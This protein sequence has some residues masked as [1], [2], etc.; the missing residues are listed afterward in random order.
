MKYFYLAVLSILCL[1]L[2]DHASSQPSEKQSSNRPWNA[3]WIAAQNDDGISY[4]VFYFRKSMVLPVKPSSFKVNVSADNRFKLYVNGILVALGPARGDNYFWNYETL[5][6]APYLVEGNNSIAALVWNEAQ[7]RPEA[8]MS[9]RTA[10]ILQGDS[11]L[12]DIINT[13]ETW[14]CV[15]D[16][17]YSALPGIFAAGI[18]EMVDMNQSILG[19]NQPDFNDNNWPAA[20]SVESGNLKINVSLSGLW[21]L[22][23]SP[24]PAMELTV[25]RIP[26]LRKAEGMIVPVSFPAHPTQVKIPANTRVTLLLDQTYLTNAYVTLNF[27]KGKNTRIGLKYAES[28]VDEFTPYGAKKMNRNDVEGKI[29]YG[30]RDSLVSSGKE[31]QTY[32]TLYWRTFRYIQLSIQTGDEP[33]IL[34]DMYG[35][36]TGYPF[37]Q[38]A[39]FNSN[40]NEIQQMLNIGWRTVRLCA[41]ETYWDCPFYEQLQYIGD[42]RIQAMVS[43]YNTSDARLAQNALTLMDHSRLPEGVTLSRYPSKGTQIISTF[44]LWYIGMLYDYWMY[45]ANPEFIRDKLTGERAILEFFANYQTEDGSLKNLPYWNFVDWA[46]GDGWFIGAPPKGQDGSSSIVD[47]QLLLAYQWASKMETALGLPVFAQ[48]YAQTAARLKKTITRKYWDSSKK[49]FSDTQEKKY[50]SQHANSLAILAGLVEGQDLQSVCQGL[51]HDKS[52][53]QC[54]LYFRYYLNQ[55]LV[56]GGWGND[57]LLWLDDWRNSINMGFTTW[58]ETSNLAFSRS[59]CHAWSSSPNIEFYRTL[60]GIDSNAP[61]FSSVKVEPHLGKLTHASGEIP[62]PKGKIAVNYIQENTAWKI[63]IELPNNTPG[64]LIW[65]EKSYRLKPGNNSFKL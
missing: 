42:T 3:Q 21:M 36:F 41:M 19:W 43:Y 23:P 58:P 38:E 18:G 60:L 4:G 26:V 49:L 17:G 46:D 11:P 22:V 53:T 37:K 1:L 55:A 62:H 57:Y 32:T 13:N 45:K 25:Q 52:L 8:Q 24:I 59:D 5:D 29:F 12:E 14:K 30:R 6:L 34:E 10:F 56:K 27:S 39:V 7:Y 35:T 51:L 33:L 48:Q 50:F 16:N 20:R 47:I 15:R 54:T 9:I 44:S 2:A 64:V 31:G 40:Y 65:K 63:N 28:L 61:G